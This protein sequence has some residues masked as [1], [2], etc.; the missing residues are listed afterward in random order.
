MTS[1]PDEAAERLLLDTS[2]LLGEPFGH[3]SAQAAISVITLAEL[4]FGVLVARDERTRATRL[5]RLE[6]VL[7]SFDPLPVDDAVAD[8]YGEIAAAVKHAGRQPRARQFDLLIAATAAAHDAT[9][10]TRNPADFAGLDAFV[11]LLVP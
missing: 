8:R 9:L 3:P 6:A 5:R 4:R 10:V 2:A 11:R 7:R 1:T